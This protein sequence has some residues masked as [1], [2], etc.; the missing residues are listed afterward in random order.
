MRTPPTAELHVHL[1][2]TLEP[3]LIFALARRNGIVLPYSDEHD[4][5]ARYAFE[6]LQSF[7]DLYYVNMAVL[8]TQQDFT[9]LTRAYLVRAARAGVRH[10]ELFFDPQAHLDRG[11]P[12]STVVSGITA[13]L[14]SSEAEHG[15][16]T[17]LIA[18]FLRDRPVEDA[19]RVL[20]E[21][22]TLGAPLLGVGLDSAEVGHPPGLFAPVFDLAREHG[23]HLVAHAGEEGPAEYVREALDVLRVERI[24]HGNRSLEDPALVDRLVAERIPLTVCP[25]SNLRLRVVHT[26][27]AHPLPAMLAKGLLVSVHSDDPSYFGGYVDDTFAALEDGLGLGPSVLAQLAHNAADAAFLEAGPRAALHSRIDDWLADANS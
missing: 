21:L 27:A 13:A 6:N 20:R 26:M 10:A 4:L 7:L 23:L 19:L 5:R 18:C 12:L 17:G 8:L 11:V 3:E 14:T 2:G 9:D 25:L 22:L 24:D 1:E 15:I 16:S